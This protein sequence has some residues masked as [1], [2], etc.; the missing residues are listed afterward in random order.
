MIDDDTTIRTPAT[1]PAGRVIA[2]LTA[3]AVATAGI[4]PQAKPARAEDEVTRG[5]PLIR[6]TEIEQLM[7][8]YAQP[9]LKAAGLAQQN[10]RV[11]ILSDRA[12]NAFVMDGRHI[13]INVGALY[14]AKTANEVIG[15]FAH[16]TGHLAGG[17]LLKL[18]EQLA[19]A[20]TAS[21]IA[22]LAGVGAMVAAGRSGASGDVGPGVLM[23]P[24]SAIMRNLLAYVRTQEDQGDH[25]GV[26][27][28]NA[29]HQ[30]PKGMVDLFKRLT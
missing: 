17:H 16:E 22:L 24:Q 3:F 12:F 2:L 5:L 27:F 4:F 7:R 28:M 6:D 25:A 23:A 1:A 21:I 29:S 15:V 20:Q 10:V 9:I 18:R 30:S 26:K 14:E 8:E 11:V 13:F 19:N